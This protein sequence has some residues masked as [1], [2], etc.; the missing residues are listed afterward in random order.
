M[1]MTQLRPARHQLNIVNATKCLTAIPIRTSLH[2]DALIQSVLDPHVR[3]AEFLK[4]VRFGA[5]VVTVNSIVLRRDDGAYML[6]IVGHTIPRDVD[7][8]ETLYSGLK[9]LGLSL[10]RLDAADIRRE[11]KL[12]SAREIWSYRTFDVPPRDRTRI[13]SAL[14]EYGPRPLASLEDIVQSRFELS[15][16]V[17]RLACEDLVEIDIATRALGPNSIVRARR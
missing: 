8:E 12:S 13:L 7:Q 5:D 9:S 3:S 2:R 1:R 4:E 16:S 17:Y 6:D 15:A 10:L 14:S 11:P